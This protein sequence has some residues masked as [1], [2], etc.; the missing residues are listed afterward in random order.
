MLPNSPPD[1][2]PEGGGNKNADLELPP[3]RE[4]AARANHTE[5]HFRFIIILLAIL[6]SVPLFTKNIKKRSNSFKAA[7]PFF[8]SISSNSTLISIL[9]DVKH[10]GIYHVT[11]NTMT[12]GVIKM[13][14]PTLKINKILPEGSEQLFVK[15]GSEYYISIT[16]DGCAKITQKDIPVSQKIILRFPL[17]I[18]NMNATEFELIPGIGPVMSKKIVEYRHKNGGIMKVSDLIMV[19]GIGEKK[20]AKL[21]F[22]FKPLKKLEKSRQIKEENKTIK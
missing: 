4:G 22:F 7:T 21:E 5:Y 20:Y 19:D 3:D 16:T 15:Y 18:N 17:D 8:N 9:G 2:P 1:L 14:E 13:A 11:A 6:V 12:I 10:P